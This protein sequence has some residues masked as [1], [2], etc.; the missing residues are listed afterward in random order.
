MRTITVTGRGAVM[1]APDSAA[2]SFTVGHRA[3]SVAEALSGCDS[4]AR[5]VGEVARRFADASRIASRTIHVGSDHD[6]EGSPS[7]FRAEHSFRV[8]CADLDAAGELVAALAE[9][10][11]DRLQVEGV[12]LQVSDPAEAR[13]AAREAAY[14]DAVV[15]GTHLAGLAQASLG[16]VQS[17]FDEHRGDRYQEA[18]GDA[19]RA[20]SKVSFE[21]GET[22]IGTTVTVTFQ[23]V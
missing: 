15:K 17:V 23:L 4:A 1:V 7:G 10:V 20:M 14:A 21:P 22:A 19:Y 18:A 5:T 13:L 3:P 6:R 11:G 16:E 9:Q 12:N 2:V 8:G